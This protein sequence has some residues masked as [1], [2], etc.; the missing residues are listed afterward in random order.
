MAKDMIPQSFKIKDFWERP[1]GVAGMI[2]GS[3]AVI[4]GGVLFYKALPYLIALAQNTIIL[5]GELLLLSGLM[6]VIVDPKFR[7]L[8]AYFYK[9][10]M[11]W[12]TSVF[13]EIDPIGILKNYIDDLK[14][15]KG[16]MD[17]RIAQLRGVIRQLEDAIGKNNRDS[18]AAL[19]LAREAQ[20]KGVQK[21]LI[22]N[23]R[24]HGR[25]QEVNVTYADMLK[26]ANFLYAVLAKYQ[27]AADIMIQDMEAQ[28]DVEVKRRDMAKSAQGAMSAAMKILRGQDAGREMYDQAMEYLTYDY[29]MKIGEIEDFVRV[30][31][32][33]VQSMDLQNGVFEADALT[34][35]E[36][37]EKKSQSLLGDEKSQLLL[38]HQNDKANVSTDVNWFEDSSAKDFI[39]R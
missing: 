22:L 20:K 6:Y 21:V 30:S 34:A 5:V 39:K 13:I 26:K 17:S 14:K 32:T 25:L 24:Q 31:E 19:K 35:I 4:G 16:N 3:I 11:R 18:E 15:S 12:I 23:S 9:S 38:S 28:V 36:D 10:V 1:E 37:W 7:K 27:D 2:F 29:G 33:F 8:L